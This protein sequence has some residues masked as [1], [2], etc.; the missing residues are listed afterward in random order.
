MKFK[1]A[2]IKLTHENLC[3]IAKKKIPIKLSRA[4][5][6]NILV[7]QPEATFFDIERMKLI[8]QY[9]KKNADGSYKTKDGCHVFEENKE[10]WD[11]GI[12]ELSDEE[13]E[14]DIFIIPESILDLLEDTEKYE[15]LT[16]AELIAIDFMLEKP[17]EEV[18]PKA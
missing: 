12:K 11:K 4:I 1:L 5:S 3:M 8:E 14:I 6:Q 2:E 17:V 13:V 10:K 9:A 18:E 7:F 15:I 16:A